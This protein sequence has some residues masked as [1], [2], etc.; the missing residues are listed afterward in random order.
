MSTKLAP[1]VEKRILQYLQPV[2]AQQDDGLERAWSTT[3]ADSQRQFAT[4]VPIGNDADERNLL[5]QYLTEQF[6]LAEVRATSELAPGQFYI[7][8]PLSKK[9]AERSR[10][11]AMPYQILFHADDQQRVMDGV[12]QRLAAL[13]QVEVVPLRQGQLTGAPGNPRGGR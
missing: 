13:A 1:G 8:A 5:A 9:V 11:P 4:H 10:L 6:G 12:N 3:L 2:K 7:V